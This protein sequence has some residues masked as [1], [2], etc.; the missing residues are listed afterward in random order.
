M[1]SLNLR[2][3]DV[4]PLI[5]QRTEIDMTLTE[6]SPTYKGKL[7]FSTAT[8]PTLHPSTRLCADLVG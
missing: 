5:E 7:A 1:P 4:D 6:R 8:P 2:N 3:M